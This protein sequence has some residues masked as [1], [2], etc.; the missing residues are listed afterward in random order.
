[1]P[2]SDRLERQART[3]LIGLS[4]AAGALALLAVMGFRLFRERERVIEHTIEVIAR[5]E[6]LR[7]AVRRAQT[8]VLDH[9]LE[10]R[11][12]AAIVERAN[13]DARRLSGELA[14]VTG[15]N[16]SQAQVVREISSKLDRLA[17]SGVALIGRP[18]G[19][20][21]SALVAYQRDT[22]ELIDDV[23]RAQAEERR[24]L[25]LRTA[26]RRVVEN[27][28][29]MAFVSAFV[30]NAA[31]LWWSFVFARN[32]RE[33]RDARDR[34]LGRLNA[35][36]ES[37]VS[38]RTRELEITVAALRR[39]NDD[40][41]RFAHSASHDL[42]EPVRV[43]GSYASL[44][45]KRLGDTLDAEGK[46]HLA[47]VVNGARQM[48]RLVADVLA[49][50]SLRESEPTL[51]FAPLSNTV[52]AALDALRLQ[53]DDSGATVESGP[54]PEV[55]ADHNLLRR[56]LQALISN[57]LKFADPERPPFVQISAR[58][59]G[60]EWIVEVKDNGIGFEPEYTGEIF[61]LFARLHPRGRFEGSGTGLA[62]ALRIVELHHGR[63]GARSRP[64][65]GSVFFFTLPFVE[66][67][68]E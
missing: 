41:R 33:A 20:L 4:I 49:Y 59:E 19:E 42:Q 12:Q 34:A 37:K 23:T 17:A 13:A 39:S 1:M 61:S 56:V 10:Q 52:E 55:A 25:A 26:D 6:E 9:A 15:D 66:R 32:Y 65:E 53:I 28:L 36:L 3:L 68:S 38:E 21:G 63:I 11:G 47:H 31:L 57:A 22:V 24:L 44:L 51:H 46:R 27:R 7:R 50:A 67:K 18:P 2:R 45:E 60:P 30:L 62:T 8:A 14:R 29:A 48:H 43:I 16:P 5:I 40:L 35:D 58:I 54:L 64:G